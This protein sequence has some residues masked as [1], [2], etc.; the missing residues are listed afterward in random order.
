MAVNLFLDSRLTKTKPAAQ[1]P[2]AA[3]PL[4]A[5]HSSG[6]AGCP[7]SLAAHRLPRGWLAMR[8]NIGAA[9]GWPALLCQCGQAAARHRS[10][11]AGGARRRA[12]TGGEKLAV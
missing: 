1:H 9:S 8:R 2:D 12:S 4:L 7:A 11:F 5:A 10:A 6:I 3:Y